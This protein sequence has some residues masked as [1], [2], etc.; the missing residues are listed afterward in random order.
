MGYRA[1][2]LA[3][4]RP[5]HDLAGRQPPVRCG[6]PAES[7]FAVALTPTRKILSKDA[8]PDQLTAYPFRATCRAIAERCAMRE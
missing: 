4:E 6:E 7:M 8:K 5:P 3:R 2:C 1:A